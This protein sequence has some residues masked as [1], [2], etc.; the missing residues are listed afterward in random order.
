MTGEPPRTAIEALEH[1]QNRFPEPPPTA[2][3]Q[4]G[5]LGHI[6]A[7]AQGSVYRDPA[8]RDRRVAA[9][10]GPV[11]A[12]DVR[13]GLL[14]V[15]PARVAAEDAERELFFAA[16]RIGMSWTEIGGLLGLPGPDQ[17]QAASDRARL[18][19]IT[20]TEAIQITFNEARS[21]P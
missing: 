21:Q 4:L 3:V 19:L 5:A 17:G 13:A 9:L 14:L 6:L 16:R 12:D 11:T 7:I 8:A 20:S 2:D 10:G 18:L 1:L 15:Q